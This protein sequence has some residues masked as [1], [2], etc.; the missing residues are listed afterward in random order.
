[1]GEV[2]FGVPRLATAQSSEKA[3][4]RLFH[5][6]PLGRDNQ[7]ELKARE[8]KAGG[9]SNDNG[10]VYKLSKSGKLVV[11]HN[12]NEGTDGAN[13]YGGEIRDKNGDF[14]GT[15]SNGGDLRCNPDF[16]CGTV[17]KLTP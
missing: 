10:A 14:Y 8:L 17:W 1:M 6:I 7:W 11:L 2:S 16:G 3:A 13:P 9:G 5:I 4:Q 15:T 12:L